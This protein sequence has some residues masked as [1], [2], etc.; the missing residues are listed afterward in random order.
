MVTNKWDQIF[1][2]VF[3]VIVFVACS[4]EEASDEAAAPSTETPYTGDFIYISSGSVFG[5]T[6]VAASTPSNT[7]YRYKSDGTDGEL[8]I[9]YALINSGDQPVALADYDSSNLLVLVENSAG[10]RIDLVKKDGSGY[11]TYITNGTA[12]NAQLRSMAVTSDGGLLVAKTSAVEKFNSSK[13]RVTQGANAYVQA[14]GGS[15]TTPTVANYWVGVGPS[16]TIL[17]V[18]GAASTSNQVNLIKSTGYA[19]TTDCLVGKDGNT[20]NHIP[21]KALYHQGSGQLIVGFSSTT[22]PIHQ[23]MAFTITSTT[24]SGGGITIF[25]DSSVV[26]GISAIAEMADGAILV[27][28]AT[29][30][31]NTIEKFTYSGGTLTRVGTSPFIPSSIFTRSISDILV[32]D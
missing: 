17:I 3:F 16:D 4:Q 12:L 24:I 28:N 30:T 19:S 15:C 13:T 32:S 26:N 7:V 6:G 20:A 21:T 23:I 27:G 2:S 14:A 25:N 8:V 5:G 22:G 18:N 10:R 1:M 11:S 9:D 29:S 31:Y